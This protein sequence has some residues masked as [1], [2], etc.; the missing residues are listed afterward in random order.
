MARPDLDVLVGLGDIADLAGVTR[1][2]VSNWRQRKDD[3]PAPRLKTP[4]GPM[5]HLA[6]VENWLLANDKIDRPIA[7]QDALWPMAEALRG[8]WSAEQVWQFVLSG[9]VYLVACQ[10]RRDDASLPSGDGWED[11][12]AEPDDRLA[13]RLMAAAQRLEA[14]D[15][16]LDGL[17][18]SG[19]SQ[20]PPPPPQLV[21]A[22]LN[23]LAATLAED[24]SQGADLFHETESRLL[25]YD[26]LSGAY[27]TPDS[28]AYLMVRLC[29]PLGDTVV[30]PAV[31]LGG[32]LLMAALATSEPP[33]ELHGYDIN[34]DALRY[35]RAWMFIYDIDANLMAQDTLQFA[36]PDQPALF[37][38]DRRPAAS[39]VLVDPPLGL[40][41]WG[42]AALYA[43]D[44]WGW[45]AP[46]PSSADLAWPQVALNLLHP[47]GRAAVVLP[48][49]ASYRG[50]REGAIRQR[51]IDDGLVEAVIH[52]PPRLRRNTPIELA[53]WL[54]R[55]TPP[56][57]PQDILLVDASGL[58]TPGRTQH[59]LDEPAIDR[60]VDLVQRWRSGHE[61]AE[62][63]ATIAA[64]VAIPDLQ[65]QATLVPRSYLTPEL[66]VDTDR[67]R[68][69]LA[70]LHATLGS[71][72]TVPLP[73]PAKRELAA[74]AI[75]RV[76]LD[77]LATLRR[78]AL[79]PSDQ[80]PGA[81]VDGTRVIQAA[82]VVDP[83]RTPRYIARDEVDTRTT[84][85]VGDLV[86]ALTGRAGTAMTVGPELD[87]AV[88]GHGCIVVR[89]TDDR[90]SQSW[91]A[92]WVSSEDF[93]T[94]LHGRLTGTTMPAV[95]PRDLGALLVP[96]PDAGSQPALLDR[97]ARH[98]QAINDVTRLLE[99]LRRMRAV[100]L[101]LMIAKT[102]QPATGPN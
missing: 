100:E 82:D 71:T 91:L 72:A 3:F 48:A 51:L 80:D 10:R 20:Q 76:P 19:F 68:T 101:T 34:E 38:D 95:R 36:A 56:A 74:T 79:R 42:D 23:A 49:G 22:I 86:I 50:G 11:I 14:D 97:I 88:L 83:N 78:G 39:T 54:L 73:T 18:T 44:R 67:L 98:D 8:E 26:R 15:Q 93:S 27:S 61:P 29:E 77:E 43:E 64:V 6:E 28:L 66:D 90:I 55:R 25:S 52:L 58:G 17:L 1:A 32:L 59:D 4:A 81:I 57:G 40:A 45:G 85:A 46:P 60:I 24:D 30:D 69:E 99:Q 63:D 102:Q 65:Q 16:R 9:L 12:Q 47:Q 84:L 53:V 89:A 2:A 96:V 70:D 94:Q 35:A 7:L 13:A 37:A 33:H 75:T 5:F 21:R 92:A 62:D 31:G 41:R 87:G